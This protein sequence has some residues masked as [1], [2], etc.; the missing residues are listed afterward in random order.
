[1]N[2]KNTFHTVVIPDLIGNPEKGRLS[3]IP[4]FAGMTDEKEWA[5]GDFDL[6]AN[7][8]QPTA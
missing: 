3:W 6:S 8:L 1:M 5:K 7:R 4:A 2:G